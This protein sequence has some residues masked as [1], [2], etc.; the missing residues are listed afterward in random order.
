MR[1]VSALFP[2]VHRTPALVII[3]ISLTLPA[4]DQVLHLA[5]NGP[6]PVFVTALMSMLLIRAGA[7]LQPSSE[8]IIAHFRKKF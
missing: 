1:V 4:H 5:E 3:F 8:E 6:C 2:S 7:D